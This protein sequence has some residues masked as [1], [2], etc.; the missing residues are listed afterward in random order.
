MDIET[1][2]TELVDLLALRFGRHLAL[3]NVRGLCRLLDIHCHKCG[4]VSIDYG[5]RERLPEWKQK[6]LRK[7]GLQKLKNRS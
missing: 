6:M 5:G 2:H 7:E 1:I 4:G 3:R